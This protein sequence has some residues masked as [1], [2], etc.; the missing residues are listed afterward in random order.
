[1]FHSTSGTTRARVSA[2]CF[3]LNIVFEND[4]FR[5]RAFYVLYIHTCFPLTHPI[6][7]VHPPPDLVY[8][9][10]VSPYKGTDFCRATRYTPYSNLHH[11]LHTLFYVCKQIIVIHNT[12]VPVRCDIDV[13]EKRKT[14]KH[15][16]RKRCLQKIDFLCTTLVPCTFHFGT[17]PI[18]IFLAVSGICST[19]FNPF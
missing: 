5:Q 8:I 11:A 9:S 17:L 19:M 4:V 14:C 2:I 15:R 12:F 3:L 1:M 13:S 18:R 7:L 16:F 6:I 10:T